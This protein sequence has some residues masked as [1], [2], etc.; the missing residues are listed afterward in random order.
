MTLNE[1]YNYIDMLL[2]KADEP[3]FTTDEKHK[4]LN[5]AI[6]EFIN[7]NYARMGVDENA[8]KALAPVTMFDSYDMSH[9][10][11]ASGGY[12]GSGHAYPNLGMKYKDDGVYD[13]SGAVIANSTHTSGNESE[14]RGWFLPGGAQMVIPNSL[15][16][17][18]SVSVI[19]YNVDDVIDS[20]TGELYTRI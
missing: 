14:T 10:D 7:V 20:S 6:S 13:T 17:I 3:Y 18:L 16:Y 11:I 9:A 2:D 1:A 8:R 4:F 5:L 12:A 15:L 19:R